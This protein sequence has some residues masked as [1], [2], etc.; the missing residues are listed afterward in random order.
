MEFYFVYKDD[1]GQW[2]ESKDDSHGLTNW[3]EW[4]SDADVRQRPIRTE[5]KGFAEATAPR[6]RPAQPTR[7]AKPTLV[8]TTEM[9]FVLKELAEDTSFDTAKRGEGNARRLA[10]FVRYFIQEYLDA[11]FENLEDLT[12]Q[13]LASQASERNDRPAHRAV[14]ARP[15]PK[16]WDLAMADD[17]TFT[18]EQKADRVLWRQKIANTAARFTF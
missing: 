8:W 12:W 9:R 4:A 6:V 7:V 11:G 1:K 10:V 16:H 18:T 3:P 14:K 17:A 2:W 5:T 15:R 13:H